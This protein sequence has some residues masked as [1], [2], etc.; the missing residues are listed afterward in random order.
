MSI[1]INSE[2]EALKIVEMALRT[3]GPFDVEVLSGGLSGSAVIRVNTVQQ[4]CVVRFWNVKWANYFP[5]DLACQLI[6]SD[7]GYGPRVFFRIKPHAP[8]F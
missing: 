5:Q 2:T 6:A 7:A 1:D 4:D 8:V 3:E